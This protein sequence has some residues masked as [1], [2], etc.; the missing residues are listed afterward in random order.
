MSGFTLLAPSVAALIFEIISG[1][2]CDPTK[3][4]LFVSPENNILENA[5]KLL[6]NSFIERCDDYK[7]FGQMIS[8]IVENNY[9][10]DSKQL[11]LKNLIYDSLEIDKIF[12][13]CFVSSF[14]VYNW[15][16]FG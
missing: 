8:E 12:S 16:S 14:Q 15:P 13:N 2:G 11:E 5:N 4:I 10:I 7:S 3:P 6:L 1:I 9:E